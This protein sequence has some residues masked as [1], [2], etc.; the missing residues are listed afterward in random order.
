[1]TRER[2]VLGILL[3]AFLFVSRP[4]EALWTWEGDSRYLDLG[5][6]IRTTAEGFQNSEGRLLFGEDDSEEALSVTQLR[7]TASGGAGSWLFGEIHGVQSLTYRTFPTSEADT[8]SELFPLRYRLTPGV[9]D[10]AET[11]D[12]TAGF[13]FDR[14]NLRCSLPGVDITL[15]R[16]PIN[17]SLT[18]FWNP[19]DVFLPFRPQEFDRDYKP[20]VDALRID[21]SLGT[22]SGFTLAA[23][24]GRR[25]D[26]VYDP[27]GQD[28]RIEA[29][30][31]SDESW[32]G[33][34]LVG[35][36]FTN[37]RNCDLVVQGG[38]V[39]GGWQIGGGFS[40]EMF[41]I[42]MRGEAAYFWV[43]ADRQEIFIPGSGFA[44]L[45]EDHASG[46][47]GIDRRFKNSLYVTLEYYFNGAGG[48]PDELLISL[49]RLA[50]GENQNLSK[51]SLGLLANY[52]ILPILEGRMVCLFSLS[53]E[54]VLLFPSLQWQATEA[55]EILAGAMIGIGD[56]PDN[57]IPRSEFGLFQNVYF[58]EIKFYF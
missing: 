33:S 46:V 41:T 19:L 3:L 44:P 6:S 4:A 26:L 17:F 57:L 35:R 56:R 23:V 37:L 45:L 58:G 43:D 18:Y 1:M 36:A 10:W 13:G 12:V 54:S 49:A 21:V 27:V 29:R 42:G 20:G 47:L 52:E 32:F 48:D 30:S 34:A 28:V 22:L 7:V 16:Q 55:L 5:G 38:K 2:T 8:F 24:A 31:F 51:Q 11:D 53:D 9:W 25:L 39:Y 15:G 14:L 40:G 50:I